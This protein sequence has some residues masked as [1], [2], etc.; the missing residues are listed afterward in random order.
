MS[1]L[2][3]GRRL[4][5]GSAG[6]VDRRYGRQ[7]EAAMDAHADISGMLGAWT[8]D[9]CS[10]TEAAAVRAHLGECADCA[11]RARRLRSAAG[12]LG[13]DS[14]Q[15]AP[16]ELRRSVLAAARERRPPATLVTLTNAYA[17]QVALLDAALAHMSP[18]DWSRADSRHG[19]VRGVL[20]HLADN[21]ALLAAD[22]GLP[23]VPLPATDDGPAM[24]VAW[25]TQAD[26]M[27]AGVGEADLDRTVRLA[28]RGQRP[29][30][31]L[32]DALV[33][34][35]F[36]TWTHRD[37]IGA[38]NPIAPPGQVHRIVGLAVALLPAAL[39]A[40]D[41][42]QADRAWRLV[43]HGSADGDWTVPAGAA[44]VEVTIGA[45]A[46][47]FARLAANRRSPRSMLHT[48]TGDHVLAEA[49]LRVV[50]TLGCD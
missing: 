24:R 7:W 23:A 43:L 6:A 41:P 42:A 36:E 33:Q 48:V 27:L 1:Q 44:R 28:G 9:G 26:A 50:T 11:A 37:D 49:I 18:A 34:R 22:L 16:E 12:W 13:I 30:R 10:D 14:V 8:L 46:V 21:D 15:P 47:D 25:R 2:E 35:A 17:D 20:G 31:T 3:F 40:S 39:R 38:M 29:A 45:A 4:A 5:A 32:R 19:D